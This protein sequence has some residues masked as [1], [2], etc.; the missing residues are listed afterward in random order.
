MLKA[1]ARYPQF[2]LPL[3]R[4]QE[5]GEKAY[6]FF[7]LQWDLYDA[8]TVPSVRADPFSGPV[9]AL[10]LDAH[11]PLPRVA[12]AIFA[13][14][15]EYKLR[16]SFAAPHLVLTF[17]PDLAS[18]HGLVLL[19]GEL[20]PRTADPAKFM[21]SQTEAQALTM[22]LQ[23]FYLWESGGK[24]GEREELLRTFHEKPEDFK[25]EDLVRLG[26]VLA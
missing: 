6:E 17:H 24:K 7:V 4:G 2:V 8:P 25:W 13:P 5:G 15:G 19:R 16:Q 20:T 18:T 21:L 26:D 10:A 9:S 1:A 22:G 23:R 11:A 3:P 12:T 14:L